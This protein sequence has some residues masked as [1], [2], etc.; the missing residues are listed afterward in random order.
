MNHKLTAI[1]LVLALTVSL[2]ACGG[3]EET[4]VSGIVMGVDGTVISL[5]QM[6]SQMQGGFGGG[7]FPVGENGEMP[8][9]PE[10]MEDFNPE[11]MEDFT[12][13]EGMEDFD[14]EKMQGFDPEKME[15][16]NFEDFNPEDMSEGF[17]PGGFGEGEPP[18]KPAEGE[19][20]EMAEATTIDIANAHI[21]LEI[22]GGKE[23]GSMSNIV[24]GTF[25]TVTL[26]SKGEA[27]YVLVSQSMGFGGFG[28]FPAMK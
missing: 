9:R 15:D 14:P 16:F 25:V 22:E 2:A 7:R 8:T 27:T 23:S 11:D 21:S 28:N 26:S 6:D 19:M 18:E 1:F 17:G 24:P 3:G 13:P 5:I 10:G 4:T 20:P 12:I